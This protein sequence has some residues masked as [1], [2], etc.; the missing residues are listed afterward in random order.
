LG[1]HHAIL[2]AP[3]K[4]PEKMPGRRSV[5]LGLLSV[6]GAKHRIKARCYC[7]THNEQVDEG[8][9]RMLIDELNHRHT[10][11]SSLPHAMARVVSGLAPLGPLLQPVH[12]PQGYRR[13]R[14]CRQKKQVSKSKDHAQLLTFQKVRE[15]T[16]ARDPDSVRSRKRHPAPRPAPSS[17]LGCR[18]SLI[19]CDNRGLSNRVGL[20]QHGLVNFLG[21]S[22]R[23]L[24]AANG[25]VDELL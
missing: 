16:P 19:L 6:S 8:P 23:D 25:K 14:H 18:D 13:D 20:G 10:A 3:V 21:E 5:R 15:Q 22:E 24:L 7:A 1:K 2:Q 4:L 9:H 11:P 17:L 12:P